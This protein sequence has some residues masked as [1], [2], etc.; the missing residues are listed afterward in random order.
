M[1]QEWINLDCVEDDH[2]LINSVPRAL[3]ATKTLIEKLQFRPA[4][5]QPSVQAALAMLENDERFKGKL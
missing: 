3:D 4:Y 2:S 1:Y 5:Q